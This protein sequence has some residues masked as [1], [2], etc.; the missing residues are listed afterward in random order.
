MEN[1]NWERISPNQCNATNPPGF[2]WF[3]VTKQYG[4]IKRKQ[5][6]KRLMHHALHQ[7]YPD[8]SVPVLYKRKFLSYALAQPSEIAFF[9]VFGTGAT[10]PLWRETRSETTIRRNYG[11]F[12][13]SCLE[14]MSIKE[15]SG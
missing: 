7:S 1:Y 11:V 4:Y 12:N 13:R 14:K 6:L 10:C 8:P 15:K 2:K 9:A 5:N 3:L